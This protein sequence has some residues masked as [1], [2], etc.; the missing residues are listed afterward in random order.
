VTCAIFLDRL[1]D[2]DARAAE[3][4]GGPI[5]PDMARHML[6]CEV[7]RAAYDVAAADELLLARTL[8]DSPPQVWR[9]E[10]LR[11]I[12]RSPRSA[13]TQRIATVNEVVAWGVLA[14]AASHVLMGEGSTAAYVAAFLTGGAAALLPPTLGKQWM[15]LLSRPFRWV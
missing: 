9:A 6:D 15:V 2:D 10:V 3:R 11:Q 4:G 5:P 14:V 12:A 13:W 8:S 1:Y 7:C